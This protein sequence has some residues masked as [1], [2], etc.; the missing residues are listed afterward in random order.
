MKLFIVGKTSNFRE[1]K[2][3]ENW[4]VLSTRDKALENNKKTLSTHKILTKNGCCVNR[5]KEKR[6]KVMATK[7]YKH[8][9]W[10]DRLYLE[11]MLKLKYSKKEIAQ[12]IGCSLATIYNEI[13]RGEYDH[14][15]SDLT[16]EKRYSPEKA[17]RKYKE[18]LS[19]KGPKP[20]IESA[21]K[22]KNYMEYMMTSLKY[23]PEAVLFEIQ[24]NKL[25]FEEK[26]TSPQTVYS[27]IRKGTFKKLTMKELPRKGK[28]KRK[29]KYVEVLPAYLKEQKGTSI[30]DRPEEISERET[31]G[32]WEMDCVIGKQTN[33]KTALVLTERKTR[34]EIVEQLKSHTTKEVVKALNRIEKRMGKAFYDI[35]QSITVDN[36]SEFK[37]FV[38]ME[39]ALRRKANRTK[40]Y[41]CHP[42]TPS[43]RGSNENNN[44][45]L[46]RCDGLGKGED[47][48][49]K[50]TYTKVKEAQFWINTYPRGIF[51]GKCSND[52]FQQEL[53]RLGIHTIC[54]LAEI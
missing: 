21:P 38:G 13:K 4:Q 18:Y 30:D 31:F 33:R 14:L 35:F 9:T 24:N 41:Y 43:E 52:L 27:A 6:R 51:D 50:L 42:R 17:Y 39:K 32:H 23:S 25:E 48:D 44:I 45:L 19:K 20:K 37:D 47:F 11:K 12:V 5:V 46:R 15:N 40:V 8:L 10:E 36:G 53:E 16:T 22:L 3:G 54:E 28:I 2:S 7:G 29:K 34:F 1:K 49:K 26:V